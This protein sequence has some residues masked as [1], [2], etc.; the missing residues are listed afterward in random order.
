MHIHREWLKVRSFYYPYTKKRILLGKKVQFC[1]RL[2]FKAVM[3][4]MQNQ[5]CNMPLC[6]NCKCRS[7]T[8]LIDLCK[9]SPREC[10]YEEKITGIK[11]NIQKSTQWKKKGVK[12]RVKHRAFIIMYSRKSKLKTVLRKK[13]DKKE[14]KTYSLNYL[15]SFNT[16]S[17]VCGLADLP[18]QNAKG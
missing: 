2:S 12:G 3:M 13:L 15:S 5:K 11:G 14:F 17:D 10:R 8:L 16:V 1:I 7:L 18:M 6:T 9:A 4:F